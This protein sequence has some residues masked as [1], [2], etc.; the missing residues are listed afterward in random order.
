ML[1]GGLALLAGSLTGCGGEPP[2][3][4]ATTAKPKAAAA[5]PAAVAPLKVRFYLEY[6]GGM[7]GFMPKSTRATDQPTEF[8]TH[9]RGLASEINGNP[10]V[11]GATYALTLT[12][13][14][15]KVQHQTVPFSQL[16]SVLQGEGPAPALGT[17][18]PELL[19][20]VLTQPNAP[21]EVSVVVSDFIYGPENRGRFSSFQDDIRDA[22]AVASKQQLAVAIYG[23]TSAFRG[24][25]FPAV[26]PGGGRPYRDLAGDYVPYYVWVMGPPEQV[27]RFQREVFAAEAPAQQVFFGLTYPQVAYAARLQPLLKPQGKVSCADGKTCHTVEGDFAAGPVEFA[28]GLDL[29]GLP[30]DQQAP[31][32]LNAQLKLDAPN[33]QAQLVPGSVRALTDTERSHP[34]LGGYTHVARLRVTR[35]FETPTTLTLRLPAPPV[36]AWVTAWATPDDANPATQPARTYR[37]DWIING[38]RKAYGATPPPLFTCP[39]SLIKKS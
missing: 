4:E 39:I 9:V 31:A 20:S 3:R 6:S 26:K 37:L 12:P 36:P 28:V 11:A 23:D 24:H 35:L 14:A 8:Q 18:M 16:K 7:K 27:Q 34:A 33:A 15:G 22:L 38:V 25:Y 5:K 13:Q 30:A 10:A 1:A 21:Q 29:A 17:E 2:R 19:E 32:T